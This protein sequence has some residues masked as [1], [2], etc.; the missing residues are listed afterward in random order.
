MKDRSDGPRPLVFYVEGPRDR[1]ILRAWAYRLMPR[2]ARSLFQASVILGGRRPER[3]LAHFA[4]RFGHVAG[5]RAI[6]VLDRDG[7]DAAAP[8]TNGYD[9]RFFTWSRR[10]IESYLR[11]PAAIRR[12]LGLPDGDRRVER[13]LEWLPSAGDEPAWRSLDAKKLLAQRGPI[14]LA[15]GRTLPLAR[16]ARSTREAELHPDVHALFGQVQ[17]LLDEPPPRSRG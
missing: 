7:G 11:V 15:L 4:E 5:A 9:L 10:H 12:A 8:D 14:P 2:G 16:I 13:L 17:G 1:S 6:C 3:A